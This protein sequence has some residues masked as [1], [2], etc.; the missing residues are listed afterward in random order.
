MKKILSSILLLSFFFLS[1]A[2]A[3]KINNYEQTFKIKNNLERSIYVKSSPLIQ[4]CFEGNSG[5]LGNG[6][7]VEKGGT[8]TFTLKRTTSYSNGCDEPKSVEFN[9]L[10]DDRVV[11]IFN[12]LSVS[13]SHYSDMDYC[14]A[15]NKPKHITTETNGH[16]LTINVN[17]N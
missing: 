13:C 2:M 15:T 10:G 7:L 3:K 8:K 12:S 5:G 11:F 14:H 4:S 9:F 16:D 6:V 17:K 1:S